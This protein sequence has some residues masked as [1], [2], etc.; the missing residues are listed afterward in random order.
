LK[1]L[2]HEEFTEGCEA[3]CNGKYDGRWSKTMLG[4]GPEVCLKKN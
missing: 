2:R 4:F 1:V 3:M